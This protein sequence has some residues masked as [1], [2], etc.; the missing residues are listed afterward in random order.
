ML[1]CSSVTGAGKLRGRCQSNRRPQS[2]KKS[3]LCTHNTGTA[4][5]GLPSKVLFF[6]QLGLICNAVIVIPQRSV[7]FCI[8]TTVT[9]KD[10]FANHVDKA[11]LLGE[12]I[13]VYWSKLF[14]VPWQCRYCHSK[15]DRN[16][17]KHTSRCTQWHV[18]LWPAG[19]NYSQNLLWDLKC[20]LPGLK[21]KWTWL[22]NLL[23][24]CSYAYFTKSQKGNCTTVFL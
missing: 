8:L 11:F 2:P 10:T 22:Q 16:D 13:E 7:V 20:E 12:N 4:G 1:C 17:P 23:R 14:V 19:L 18:S 6:C 24:L 21:C 5:T 15:M 9:T 3:Y